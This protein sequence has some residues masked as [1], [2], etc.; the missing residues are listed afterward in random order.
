MMKLSNSDSGLGTLGRSHQ[1]AQQAAEHGPHVN[2]VVTTKAELD[3]GQ[4][5]VGALGELD[6]V[7]RPGQ[8]GLDVA[9]ERIDGS[10]LLVEHAGH[11]AAGDLAVVHS[12]QAA[13]HGEAAQTIGD[14]G[15]G[16][17]G[18]GGEGILKGRLRKWARRQADKV[19][20]AALGALH[21]LRR[22]APCS[23][24]PVRPCHHRV[25]HQGRRRRTRP[26]R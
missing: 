13:D 8:R 25:R 18:D 17:H 4:V 11:V 14:D 15:Q 26:V 1:R 3:L 5:A 6:G 23:P 21:G 12:A 22:T 20:L 16:Q 7:V 9:D 2:V 10:E 19:R 24:S